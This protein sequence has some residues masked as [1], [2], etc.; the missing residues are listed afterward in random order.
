MDAMEPVALDP[1]MAG[2]PAPAEPAAAG[3][4]D[5]SC[6]A[7]S[8]RGPNGAVTV[9]VPLDHKG[10]SLGTIRLFTESPETV[11]SQERQRLLLSVGRHLGMSIAKAS[12]DD[13]SKML[14]IV[15]ERAA[16]AHELHD[17]LAQTLA[18]LRLQADMLADSLAGSASGR[19]PRSL[20][21]S[22][23]RWN[24]PTSSCGS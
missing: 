6:I 2:T 22:R 13:E 15:R 10:V 9:T 21:A 19:P 18:S 16:I 8:A 1:G 3:A 4:L 12:T 5:E 24:R 17:S 11:E 14:S 20:R 7:I 23:R